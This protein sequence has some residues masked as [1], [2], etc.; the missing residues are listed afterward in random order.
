MWS[1]QHLSEIRRYSVC[2]CKHGDILTSLYTEG[3]CLMQ[4]PLTWPGPDAHPQAYTPAY[5]W[6]IP[7]SEE[8]P[9]TQD[10]GCPC[11]PESL[12]G[13]VE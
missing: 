9:S 3:L 6:Q 7:I 8:V 1:V 5:P 2:P 11:F 12:T 13:E 10:W 4:L